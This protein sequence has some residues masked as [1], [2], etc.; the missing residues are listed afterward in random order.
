MG[1]ILLFPDYGT[2]RRILLNGLLYV[3]FGNSTVWDPEL[4]I[5]AGTHLPQ[6]RVFVNEFK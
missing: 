3:G 4:R 6:V 5:P 1:R 2:A